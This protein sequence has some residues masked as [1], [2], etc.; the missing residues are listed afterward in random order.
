MEDRQPRLAPHSLVR[1]VLLGACVCWTPT[2]EAQTLAD[3]EFGT[4]GTLDVV[5]WN[6]QTFPKDGQTTTDQVGEI[7]DGLDADL[8]ALQEI[9][10]VAE[11]EAIAQSL[12]EY[13]AFYFANSGGLAWLYK[14]STVQITATYEIFESNGRAFPRDPVVMEFLYQGEAVVAINNHWKCCGDDLLD[15]N[16]LWDEENR[17][18]QASQLMQQYVDTNFPDARVIVLGDLNDNLPDA[19]QHN[20]FQG[21]LDAPSEYL[22]TDLAIANGP[23]SS[24]SYPNWPSH[25]DHILIT[26][27]LF[28]AFNDPLADVQTI[29]IGDYLPGGFSQYDDEISDHRPVALKLPFDELCL[30]AVQS[31]ELFR[32]GSPP[33]PFALL[34]GQTS[35]PVIGS[36]WDPVVNHT[37]FF[38]SATLDILVVS[39]LP[40]INVS[41]PNGT[42]VCN[43]P[44]PNQIFFSSP[45]VPFAISIPDDCNLAGLA[46]CTQAA[47]I[48]GGVI[49]VTNGI[50]LVLGTQ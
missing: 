4:A 27:E 6:I 19:P 11:L 38:P 34:N 20:V 46:L 18:L 17:R 32:L 28:D 14:P 21:F 40:P 8:Y 24:W 1:A 37:T 15:P 5:T 7:F 41:T 23:I 47:S 50:D 35:G 49:Q 39:T 29:R 13:E 48:G 45:S 16:N 22:F 31:T 30:P 26:D 43:I 33:N 44:G 25:L 9:N 10:D 2:L 42:V 36:V 3:L 12:P